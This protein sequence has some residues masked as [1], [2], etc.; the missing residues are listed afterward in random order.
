M[1]P[2]F[3]TD[4]GVTVGRLV[5]GRMFRHSAPGGHWH[6]NPTKHAPEGLYKTSGA[7]KTRV[8]D[9]VTRMVGEFM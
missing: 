1:V 4:G 2:V 3:H 6:F 5:I 7:D 9:E 8:M